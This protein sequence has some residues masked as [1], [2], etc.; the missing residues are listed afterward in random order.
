MP[1]V[2]GVAPNLT[3]FMTR[4]TFAGS[5]FNLYS[6]QGDPVAGNPELTANP[7]DPGDALIG[8]PVD[9]ERVNRAVLEAW[10]RNPPAMKPAYAQGGRGMP[11]LAPDR[12]SDR[13]TR[14]LPRDPQVT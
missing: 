6:P 10:L 11:N 13:S 2:A 9:T 4:G 5:I 7:G 1:L 3:H 12:G 8:G 14:R